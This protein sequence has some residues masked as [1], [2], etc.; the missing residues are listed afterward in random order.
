MVRRQRRCGLVKH[1]E[2]V[3]PTCGLKFWTVEIPAGV[4][5]QVAIQVGL[6]GIEA[7]VVKKR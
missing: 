2:I 4:R 1:G 7:E 6:D 5:A 3:G